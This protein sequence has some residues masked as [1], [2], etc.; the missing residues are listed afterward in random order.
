[1]V[2]DKIVSPEKR[3]SQNLRQALSSIE[4]LIPRTTKEIVINFNEMV[5]LFEEVFTLV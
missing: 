2:Q 1:M 5:T 4:G 3:L